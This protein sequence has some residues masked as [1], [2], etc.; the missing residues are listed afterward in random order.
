MEWISTVANIATVAGVGI[1]LYQMRKDSRNS[2]AAVVLTICSS[3][4]KELESLGSKSH[5]AIDGVLSDFEV[6][7]RNL[8]NEIE[9]ASAIVL[10]GAASGRSG[11]VVRDLLLDI[12]KT[13][14]SDTGLLE[15]VA[16]AIH[17]P[18][19]YRNMREFVHKYRRQLVSLEK[20]VEPSE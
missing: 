9:L 20:A 2:S 10:D 15:M 5:D 14:Q 1:V 17:G 12:L 16:K 6:A 7:F 11:A 19:T 3:I 13:L 18:D 4:R 8:L